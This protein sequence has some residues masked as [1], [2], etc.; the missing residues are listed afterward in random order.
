MHGNLR[1]WLHYIQLRCGPETQLEHRQ[2]AEGC[3]DIFIDQF[4]IIAEAAFQ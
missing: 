1:S 4:P 2:V 3:R